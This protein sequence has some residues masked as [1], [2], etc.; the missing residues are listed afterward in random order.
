MA[1]ELHRSFLPGWQCTLSSIPRDRAIEGN[2]EFPVAFPVVT[3]SSVPHT[4]P[5][6]LRK[7]LQVCR[8]W[9]GSSRS[10]S[11][12]NSPRLR[13][14]WSPVSLTGTPCVVSQC[15]RQRLLR[16]R[17]N[18]PQPFVSRHAVCRQGGQR[19][20]PRQPHSDHHCSRRRPKQGS[21]F[22]N[23]D[24]NAD[25]RNHRR[26]QYA[27]VAWFSFL[28]RRPSRTTDHLKPSKLHQHESVA[29]RG[30]VITCGFLSL[31]QHVT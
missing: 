9:G 30:R 8:G 17:H 15:Y 19:N 20:R 2:R 29:S 22:G 6:L 11:C 10:S 21:V 26:Q 3:A 14:A 5:C 12:R 7:K 4:L 28:V 1:I 23:A 13:C 18:S 24:G 25:R 16:T 31:W 27:H